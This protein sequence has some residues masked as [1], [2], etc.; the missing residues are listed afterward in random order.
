MELSFGTLKTILIFFGPILL[1]KAIS[2]YRSIRA[3]PQIQGL[4]I[5]PVPPNVSR[6][7]TILFVTSLAFLIKTF[8]IF[9]TPDLFTLTQSR[10][11]TPTDVLFTRLQAQRPNGFLPSDELL[12]S[13]FVSLDSRLLYLKWGPEAMTGCR[14]CDPED[15]S[16][17]IYSLTTIAAPHL[18][19]LGI[20]GLVTSGLFTGKEGSFWRGKATYLAVIIAALDVYF[21]ASYDHKSNARSM[22]LEDISLFYWNMQLYRNIALAAI[23]GLIGWL[24]YL[25]STNRA[26]LSPPTTAEKIEASTKIMEETRNKLNAVALVRNASVRDK[27]LRG[28]VED[29]WV[30]EGDFMREMLETREVVDGVRNALESRVNLAAVQR[31]ADAFANTIL[32]DEVKVMG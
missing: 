2:Y 23:D 20:L 12:R 1:P 24:L 29:Y 17:L 27:D 7:L 14:F 13:K 28:K 16:Y 10:L 26:F 8:P 11:Q 25:S 9:T 30:R 4:S 21:V 15:H 3:A 19:N 32:G 22:R 5:R 18:F 31:E 6:A